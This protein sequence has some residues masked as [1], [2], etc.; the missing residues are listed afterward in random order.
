VADSVKKRLESRL[1]GI[2]GGL[3]RFGI[4]R[5]GKVLYTFKK[6]AHVFVGDDPLSQHLADLPDIPIE[7][8]RI[9]RILL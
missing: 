5:Q 7:R 2:A 9:L 8:L 6:A 3:R 4:Q 1:R